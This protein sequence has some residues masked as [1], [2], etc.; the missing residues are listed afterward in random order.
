MKEYFPK[1]MVVSHTSFTASDSMGS[2]LA[3][4]LR[5]YPAE[6]TAQFYIKE[7]TPDIPVC[8][9]YFKVTDKEL[10][11]KILHPI[12]G[13]V[14]ERVFLQTREDG[15]IQTGSG[16]V[17]DRKGSFRYRHVGMLLRNLVWSTGLWDNAEFR[18]WIHEFKPEAIL[19]QP[20]DFSYLLKMAVKLS[21][22]LDIPLVVH[23]SEAYYLKRYEKKSLFY[24]MYRWD[25][26]RQFRKMMKRASACVYLC[27]AL[28]E[29]Y[30]KVFDTPSCTIMKASPLQRV[31]PTRP[32]GEGGVRFVYGGNLGEAVGRCEPLVQLGRAVKKCGFHIDVYTNST[33]EHMAEL[34]EENGIVL[35]GALPYAQL[36]EVIR[37]SD[38]VLHMENQSPWH[39]EDLK[40]AFTTKIADMLA[41]GICSIVYGSCDIASIR[42][43][44]EHG[45][46]CVI[47]T[48]DDLYP[49]IRELI[50]LSEMREAYIEAA[51]KQAEREHDPNV[52]ARAMNDVILKSVSEFKYENSAD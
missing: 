22:K 52:T 37:Q 12:R 20:G 2:T 3:S 34:T 31:R 10:V 30:D 24:R 4:Y 45:L 39:R 27:E 35:H 6:Q 48:E 14:G 32:F 49:R 51:L 13:R 17:A 26:A 23:Q 29:D 15:S 9:R 19:V 36:Q 42:Y 11:Q 7:M 33:G 21:E 47:E 1:L 41:S 40:Y 50:D 25:F 16:A 38:F 44:K 28:Q 18:E 5:A 8:Q 43:F 46:G